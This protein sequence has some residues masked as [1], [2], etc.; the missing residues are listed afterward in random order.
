MSWEVKVQLH[1]FL[2][3]ALYGDEWSASRPGRFIPEERAAGTQPDRRLGVSQSRLGGRGEKENI[4]HYPC[5]ELNPDRPARRLVS[6]L[7]CNAKQLI[8]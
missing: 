5:R 7:C 1:T 2:T 4:H 8:S 6:T 3:S